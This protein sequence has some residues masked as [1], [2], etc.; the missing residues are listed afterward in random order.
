MTTTA[1]VSHW[2]GLIDWSKYPYKDVII[3]AG[4]GDV[5]KEESSFIR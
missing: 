1:D 2:N 5:E 3:K 4:G